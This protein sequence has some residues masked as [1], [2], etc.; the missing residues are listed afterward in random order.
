MNNPVL[1][2]MLCMRADIL[3]IVYSNR[4]FFLNFVYFCSR[5]TSLWP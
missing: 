1:V 4:L 3:K 2:T 5:N